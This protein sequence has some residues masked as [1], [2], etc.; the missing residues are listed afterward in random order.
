[1]PDDVRTLLSPAFDEK[2][3]TYRAVQYFY[4]VESSEAS[5]VRVRVFNS[6]VDSLPIESAIA[7]VNHA[8]SNTSFNYI[9]TVNKT[10]VNVYRMKYAKGD[11]HV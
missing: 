6:R 10:H 3:A 9:L 4:N 1:M 11:C 8:M 2:Y 5:Y 7:A